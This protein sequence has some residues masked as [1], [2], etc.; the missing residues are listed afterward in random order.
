MAKVIKIKGR[1]AD[2]GKN[3]TDYIRKIN[4]NT[5]TICHGPAGTGKTFIAC[6]LAAKSFMKEDGVKKIVLTRPIASCGADIGF[7]PGDVMEKIGP[8]LM[9][10]FDELSNFFKPEEMKAMFEDKTIEIVPLAMMRG[11]TF[12][13]SFIILDEAQNA[14]Y[15]ELKMF[16]T[17]LGKDSKMIMN[18]D[19]DQTDIDDNAFVRISRQLRNIDDIAHAELTVDDIVRHGLISKILKATKG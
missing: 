11:R 14:I 19:A 7:L 17:R 1:G 9:P 4:S 10:L 2:N 3:Q 6:A 12:N 16:L 8:Y 18:G 5:V 13:D 15:S